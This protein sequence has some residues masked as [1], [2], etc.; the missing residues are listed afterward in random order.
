MRLA[1]HQPNYAPWCGYFA[2]IRHCDI[3]VFL[4]DAQ[5]PGGQSYVYRTQMRGRE[6]PT[7]L[8]VP[9]RFSLGDS[10][11][12]VRFADMRWA[13]K[14]LR[15]FRTQYGR[16]SCFLEVMAVL[17]PIY[18]D[19]GERLAPFNE[20]LIRAVA[21]YLG[22]SNRFERSGALGAHG[23]SDSRLIS[24][25]QM[26]H[27]D[28]YVSGP[29]GQKYQDAMAFAAAGIR[30]EVRSYIPVPYPQIHGEFQDGLTI[31][32]ALFHLG[33]K[34]VDLLVYPELDE[35]SGRVMVSA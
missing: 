31:L 22:L 26:L 13:Q 8:S 4:D 20:R 24:L 32:D 17:E 30:L 6:E 5:M 35:S 11:L 34:T 1:V 19:P 3:F 28:T 27:A 16:C 23:S 12:D 25:A 10:I 2:K 7:W 21:D 18:S 29:G 33:R 9:T 15:T 14:H